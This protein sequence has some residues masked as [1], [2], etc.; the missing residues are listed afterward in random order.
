MSQSSAREIF[1]TCLTE[2][3][4]RV[5]DHF[6][7]DLRGVL[8][9]GST[10]KDYLKPETD[11]DMIFIFSQLPQLRREKY[12]LLSSLEKELEALLKQKLSDHN[13]VLSPLLRTPEDFKNFS[14]LYLD[15]VEHSVIHYDPDG[16]LRSTLDRTKNWIKK[17]GAYKV[18]Q[19]TKWYWVI[20][21]TGNDTEID[22]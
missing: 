11:I 9:F 10:V 17:S 7:K 2:W 16:L 4:K 14:P 18:T 22:W 13:F 21:P 20:N 1:D 19:G 3:V 8:R 5:S 12:A 6:G 15:M